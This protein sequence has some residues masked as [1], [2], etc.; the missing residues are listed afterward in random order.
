MPRLSQTPPA[1]AGDRPAEAAEVV[2]RRLA[3]RRAVEPGRHVDDVG[4]DRDVDRQRDARRWAA[5]SRLESEPRPAVVGDDLAQ[6]RAEADARRPAARSQAAANSSEVSRAKPK[7]PAMRRGPTSS[8]VRPGD[9]QLEVMDRRRAVHGEAVEDAAVDPVDQVR[10]APRL[11][12]RGRPSPRRPVG[13]RSWAATTASRSR[14]KPLPA[15]WR[16]QGVDPVGE[17]RVGRQGPAEVGERRPCSAGRRAARSGGRRGRGRSVSTGH[18]FP[19]RS[20]SIRTGRATD[21]REGVEQDRLPLDHLQPDPQGAAGPVR[22]WPARSFTESF[23]VVKASSAPSP[24]AQA[25][26]S[27]TSAAP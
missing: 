2:E 12:R 25:A 11:D 23:W 22:G 13:P 26:R 16:G 5:T 10:A 24:P 7:V 4:A 21:P 1:I 20:P 8:L 15:S 9:R 27:A 14:R 17:R 3:E 18:P 6:G 19:R